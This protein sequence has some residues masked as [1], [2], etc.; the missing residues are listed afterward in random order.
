M[1]E[2][3]LQST[4]NQKI[5][6][7]RPLLFDETEFLSVLEKLR[8]QMDDD[9]NDLKPLIKQLVP[10]FRQETSEQPAAKNDPS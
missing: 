1:D 2:E 6:I 3:G 9:K 7:G 4:A 8:A 5:H 10:T